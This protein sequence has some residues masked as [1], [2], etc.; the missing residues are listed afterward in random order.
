MS[1]AALSDFAKGRPGWNRHVLEIQ[2]E[3]CMLRS[4]TGAY[5]LCN[6]PLNLLLALP[7]VAIDKW[8]PGSFPSP[9]S[10]GRAVVRAASHVCG[11][12][13]QLLTHRSPA[14]KVSSVSAALL[15]LTLIPLVPSDLKKA[16]YVKH[17]FCSSSPPQAGTPA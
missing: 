14:S 6:M 16:P 11:E 10:G 2:N 13:R 15:L 4:G 7:R 12:H 3:N 5:F 1:S 8:N 9:V 17:K